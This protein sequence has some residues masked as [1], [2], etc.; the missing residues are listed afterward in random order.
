MKKINLD[1]LQLQL[2][3]NTSP[4]FSTEDISMIMFGLKNFDISWVMHRKFL[5]DNSKIY[6]FVRAQIS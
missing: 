5:L 3:F 2:L 6:D 1:K 4:V